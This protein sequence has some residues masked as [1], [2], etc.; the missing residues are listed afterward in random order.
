MSYAKPMPNWN[1]FH[2]TDIQQNTVTV[3]RL[4]WFIYLRA[5]IFMKLFS[6]QGQNFYQCTTLKMFQNVF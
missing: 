5:F 1:I 6:Y 3:L 2:P 4:V